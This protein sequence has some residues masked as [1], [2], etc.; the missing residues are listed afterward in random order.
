MK[1]KFKIT[2]RTQNGP[3]NTSPK[4]VK[5]ATSG[6]SKVGKM[7]SNGTINTSRVVQVKTAQKSKK[8]GPLSKTVA[9]QPKSLGSIKKS[10]RK[11]M[12]Y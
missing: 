1:K 5:Y 9:S 3:T 12:G 10:L 11:T 6:R 2:R 8:T 7:K 4:A